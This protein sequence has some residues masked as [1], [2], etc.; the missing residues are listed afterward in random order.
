MRIRTQ[1]VGAT[2]VVAVAVNVLYAF[3]FIGS[4]RSDALAR[5]RA[6]IR[7]NDRL[8][9]V[10]TAGPLYDGN[11]EELN[12]DLDSFFSDPLI[13]RMVLREYGG[14]IVIR[15]ERPLSSPLGE[16][17][18]SRVIIQRG[19]DELGEIHI[20]YST[21]LIERR[22]IDSRNEI[23]FFSALLMLGLWLVIYLVARRL[24]V[25]IDRFT[26]AAQAMADGDLERRIDAG[27]TDEIASLGRS[28]VRMRD[29][30]REKM[31][32]LAEKNEA[33]RLEMDE[34]SRAQEALHRLNDELEQ[35]V[36]ERTEEL[37]ASN[38]R[39]Q[40][41]LRR[42][43]HAQDELVRSEKLAGL[44]SLVAGVAHEMGSP[45][46][47]SLTVATTLADRTR[48]FATTVEGATLS[49]S[50]LKE[51]LGRTLQATDLLVRSMMQASELIRH[52]KQVAVDQTS[53]QRR[54]FDLADVVTEVA[55]TLQPQFKRTPHRIDV[56][57]PAGI[58]MDSFPGPLGQVITNLANNALIH[59][60]ADGPPGTVTIEAHTIGN[61]GVQLT[62]A[63]TG[64]GI[65]PEHMP[66]IFDP[67]FTTRLGQG[68]SGLGL[69]IVYRITTRIL[70][71]RI[72]AS[73]E[74]GR[75]AKFVLHLPTSAPETP[76]EGAPWH[77]LVEPDDATLAH[78][79]T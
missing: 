50:A 9:Q 52:F 63:D 64:R 21:A 54:R 67:F 23:I 68:G 29:A 42:L 37:A 30:I 27:D 72:D 34:R 38:R 56:D 79:E 43:Q 36:A 51:F 18:E 3:Y 70:G 47:N 59:G 10:V 57:V 8:L 24:T 26:A 41:T 78:R 2:L 39:L 14:D 12:D 53:A 1:F 69:P 55:A 76:E 75:G 15:R 48:E 11:V 13:V 19:L 20:V 49:R 73:S 74:P 33:L 40:E 65:A 46:G 71:G 32:A 35:R 31:A 45:L 77:A 66:R 4:E 16:T 22:L 17:T 7:E 61:D 60:L 58:A 62:V 25:P 28:F 44:G 5:L 6:T